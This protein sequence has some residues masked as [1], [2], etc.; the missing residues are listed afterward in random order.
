MIESLLFLVEVAAMCYVAF[1]YD[2][3]ERTQKKE[4]K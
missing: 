1:L 4:K 2:Q 3:H